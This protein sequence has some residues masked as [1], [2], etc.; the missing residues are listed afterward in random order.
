MMSDE[1]PTREDGGEG[2]G[3]NGR[4]P[5]P[6]EWAD[7]L[8]QPHMRRLRIWY[9]GILPSRT[10]GKEYIEMALEQTIRRDPAESVS[11]ELTGHSSR[12]C[13]EEKG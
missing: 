6:S 3:Q 13:S 4:A 2:H 5:D 11:K 12:R 7:W 8:R 10:K 9:H 1:D